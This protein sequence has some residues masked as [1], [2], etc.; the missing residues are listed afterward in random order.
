MRAT[1]GP[2]L[3]M[4]V[5][6]A[7]FEFERIKMQMSSSSGAMSQNSDSLMLVGGVTICSVCGCVLVRLMILFCSLCTSI[8]Q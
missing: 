2:C 5:S 6:K 1:T 8:V 7:M 4:S 3:R